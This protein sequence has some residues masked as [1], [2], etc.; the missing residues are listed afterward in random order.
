VAPTNS[1]SSGDSDTDGSISRFLQTTFNAYVQYFNV[2]ERYSGT[3]FQG[4]AK[5]REVDTDNYLKWIV[6][7]IHSNPV[8]ASLVKKTLEWKH[9]DCAM[10]IADSDVSFSAKSLRDD[11]FGDGKAYQRFLESCVPETFSRFPGPFPGG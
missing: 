5:S 9:S 3:L 11:L 8:R 10:W 4:P 1:R 2:L 6:G 7:Y